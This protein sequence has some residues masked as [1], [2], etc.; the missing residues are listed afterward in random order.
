[1]SQPQTAVR[2]ALMPLDAVRAAAGYK[3]RSALYAAMAAGLYPRS[4][5]NGI[6]A[7]VIPAYEVEAINA[8]RIRGDSDEQVRALVT[9]LH[10]QRKV[11]ALPQG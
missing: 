11:G 1:M 3:S 7:A 5:K 4:L 10:E 9:K 6:R 2:N 8:A